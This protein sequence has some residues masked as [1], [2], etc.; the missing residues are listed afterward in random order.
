[1]SSLRQRLFSRPARRR[2]LA[3][4]I[5][6]KRYVKGPAVVATECQFTCQINRTPNQFPLGQFSK[7][8]S[9][10]L[11]NSIWFYVED[12]GNLPTASMYLDMCRSAL[13]NAVR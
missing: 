13:E 4:E 1:M 7:C 11:E 10:Y 9:D 5:S 6:N 12:T 3:M 8:V 2:V